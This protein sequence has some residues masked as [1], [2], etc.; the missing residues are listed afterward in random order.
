LGYYALKPVHSTK[1]LFYNALGWDY[2][3]TQNWVLRNR[4]KAHLNKADYMEWG[5]SY[6]W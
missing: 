4:L 1:P 5:F 2:R 3:L 6:I